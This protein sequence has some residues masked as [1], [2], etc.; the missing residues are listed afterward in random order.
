MVALA[1]VNEL[2]ARPNKWAAALVAVLFY[3]VLLFEFDATSNLL[4]PSIRL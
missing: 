1:L 4:V 3:F 2:I